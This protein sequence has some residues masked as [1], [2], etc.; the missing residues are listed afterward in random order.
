M[1]GWVLF[2]SVGLP[3]WL[4]FFVWL[5]V[6]FAIAKNF[7]TLNEI[8]NKVDRI[9]QSFEHESPKMAGNITKTTDEIAELVRSLKDTVDVLTMTV[10]AGKTNFK[11][12]MGLAMPFIKKGLSKADANPVADYLKRKKQ[13]G[14]KNND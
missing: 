3:L 4:L 7:N 13:R 6:A 1:N 10:V 14:G 8:L 12:I 5:I 2:F 9:V 11:T